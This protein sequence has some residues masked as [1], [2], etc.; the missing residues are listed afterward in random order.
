MKIKDKPLFS[1]SYSVDNSGGRS[2]GR[3]KQTASLGL[4]SP[5]GFGDALNLTALHSDGVDYV[6]AAYN[7]PLGGRGLQLGLNSSYLEYTVI[8]KGDVETI[9]PIGRSVVYGLDLNY[10]LLITKTASLNV[11]LGYDSKSFLNQR[12]EGFGEP[13]LNASDYKVDVFSV[14]L[15]GNYYDGLLAGGISN[16]SLNFANGYVNLDGSYDY[17]TSTSHKV[18]DA[19]SANTQ[20][21]YN[22]LKWNLSRNQYLTETLVLSLDASGQMADKNLDSSEKFYLGGVGGVRAYPTSEGGGSEGYLFKVELRKF[23]PYN[24][25]ASIFMDDGRVKQYYQTI[26]GDGDSMLDEG[27][28]NAYHL[29]GYGATLAW[30]GPYKSSLKAIFARRMGSNP[31]P[32]VDSTTEAVTDQDG[33]LVRDVFWLS[34][35]IAF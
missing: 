2:T 15:S 10:P 9:R 6:S 17:L 8:T 34:G 18:S 28:P 4:A 24:F 3:V 11:E 26:G 35:G 12:R 19:E 14:V 27:V 5:L 30:N 13:Y 16:A 20:G 1:G 31:N 7:I 25:N 21:A 22:R 33:S 29:R 32:L 23:L